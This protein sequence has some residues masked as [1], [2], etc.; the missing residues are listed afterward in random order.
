MI[1]LFGLT[2]IAEQVRQISE[3]QDYYN[4]MVDAANKMGITAT[5]DT[6]WE[7]E[8]TELLP[9]LDA[10]DYETLRKRLSELRMPTEEVNQDNRISRYISKPRE[11]NRFYTDDDN[12][13]S[14]GG[15][16]KI[17]SEATK[18][19]LE[20]MKQDPEAYREALLGMRARGF[21]GYDEAMLPSISE[22]FEELKK[23]QNQLFNNTPEV[24]TNS[25]LLPPQ[26]PLKRTSIG[27][28][29]N[30]G[31]KYSVNP[32][33]N[34]LISNNNSESVLQS[35]VGSKHIH[36]TLE[37]QKYIDFQLLQALK[38]IRDY[39]TIDGKRENVKDD[40]NPVRVRDLARLSSNN[41]QQVLPSNFLLYKHIANQFPNADLKQVVDTMNQVYKVDEADVDF[42]AKMENLPSND[43]KH[44]IYNPDT[45]FQSSTR[46][47]LTDVA[48]G[49]QVR[50]LKT[51]VFAHEPQNRQSPAYESYQRFYG[52]SPVFKGQKNEIIKNDVTTQTPK[53]E[54]P[55]EVIQ[56]S[57]AAD[58]S[59]QKTT[60]KE[61]K[62][63]T[64]PMRLPVSK[65]I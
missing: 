46:T 59:T 38:G 37:G 31:G 62:Y 55:R 33:Q 16:K 43:I 17:L 42:F 2:K 1:H 18:S 45:G 22:D 50:K 23:Y 57:N 3:L 12:A 64:I 63:F 9:L 8:V 53:V 60:P 32:L 41:P 14:F 44:N 5:P 61:T 39:V 6:D 13:Q 30:L 19:Y 26:S 29:V 34:P 25:T 47:K 24:G 54:T 40:S 58:L 65:K 21:I 4:R 10:N 20:Q 27:E 49:K 35:I 11:W 36:P 7:E 52:N 56:Q 51:V 48:P 28:R 15:T